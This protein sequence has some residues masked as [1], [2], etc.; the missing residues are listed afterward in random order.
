MD[1]QGENYVR[2]SYNLST[3]KDKQKQ[4]KTLFSMCIYAFPT[5]SCAPRVCLLFRGQKKAPDTLELK[6]Q[7]VV[8]HHVQ[9]DPNSSARATVLLSAEPSL[10]SSHC[11]L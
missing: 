4:Q 6:L 10:Q 8:S 3:I 2:P 9:T 5:Y 1:N 11:C 7:V